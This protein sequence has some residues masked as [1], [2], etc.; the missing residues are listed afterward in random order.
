MMPVSITVPFLIFFSR[1]LPSH[2]TTASP[3]AILDFFAAFSLLRSRRVFFQAFPRFVTVYLFFLLPKTTANAAARQGRTHA[4]PMTDPQ[5]LSVF[6]SQAAYSFK[7]ALSGA[8]K[9]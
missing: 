7:S 8:E 2:S 1:G 3:R 5:P 9:S 4:A 6:F